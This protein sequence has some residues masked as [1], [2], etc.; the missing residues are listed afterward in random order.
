[1]IRL[2]VG[3]SAG[4]DLESQAVL[5]YT[6]R[7][8]ASEPIEIVW[9]QQARTGFWGGWNTTGWGTPFTGF[10]WG[11]PA[12][13]GYQGRAIYTDSDFI[14][15]ADLAELWHQDMHGKAILLRRTDGKLKT[16]CLLFDC[17]EAKKH[18]PAFERMK[19]MRD[20]NGEMCKYFGNHRDA[21][22]QFDG[23]WNCVDLKGYEDI[24]DSRIK[25]IHYSRM[26]C[27]PHL[28]YAIPR[29]AAEG[30]YHWYDGE[31]A[32]H[33]RSDLVA[34]FDEL[35]AEAREAGYTPDKYSV[36]AFGA[37]VKKSWKGFQPLHPGLQ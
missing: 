24:N 17:A 6:A 25:A 37:Y 35:Y 33:W 31:T 7:K 8:H 15:R 34:L 4:E 10:R 20:Q 32:M 18:L 36:P 13:C 1:M 11:I 30:R 12:F 27:Q 21:I 22:G 2:F 5:E 9:M 28:K 14:F 26:P 23:D 16:C 29:L 3:C 19:P